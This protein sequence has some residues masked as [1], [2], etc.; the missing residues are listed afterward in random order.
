MTTAYIGNIV[1]MILRGVR[2]YVNIY[3]P[4]FN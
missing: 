3:I 1:L 2:F 4:Q